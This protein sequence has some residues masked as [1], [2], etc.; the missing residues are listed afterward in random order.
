M[1][2]RGRLVGDRRDCGKEIGSASDFAERQNVGRKQNE[3]NEGPEL[4]QQSEGI[5]RKNKWMRARL[6]RNYS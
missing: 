2:G 1:G 5:E 6:E 4:E 3:D